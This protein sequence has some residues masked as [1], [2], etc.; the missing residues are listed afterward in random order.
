M[1]SCMHACHVQTS[2]DWHMRRR[3]TVLGLCV[4]VCVCVFVCVCVCVCSDNSGHRVQ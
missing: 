2:Y 4:C 1:G 3:V